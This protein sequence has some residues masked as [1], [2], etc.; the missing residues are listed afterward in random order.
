[1]WATQGD[2]QQELSA[3]VV[4]LSR[5]GLVKD[6][7]IPTILSLLFGVFFMR[8]MAWINTNMA[9]EEFQFTMNE[10]I[11]LILRGIGL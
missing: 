8:F 9:K 3:L 1:L 6:D 4:P 11:N 2:F 5:T 7:E 10:Q